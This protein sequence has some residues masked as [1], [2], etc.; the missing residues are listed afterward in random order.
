[1]SKAF[2]EKHLPRLR[3]GK[4]LVAPSGKGDEVILLARSG[5]EVTAYDREKKQVEHVQKRAE[6]EQV[7]IT[8]EPKDLDMV[9]LPLLSFDTIILTGPKPSSRYFSEISRSLAQGGTVLIEGLSVDE[10]V[11]GNDPDLHPKSVLQ[12]K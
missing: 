1:M 12:S 7:K 11:R 2:L 4:A 3:T 5:F 8:G 9:I 10:V 6:V